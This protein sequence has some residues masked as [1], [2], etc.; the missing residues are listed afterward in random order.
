[1]SGY[2]HKRQW[3]GLQRRSLCWGGSCLL[4][5]TAGV[6][7]TIPER[8]SETKWNSSE[9]LRHWIQRPRECSR[10]HFTFLCRGGEVP[11][12]ICSLVY[13]L[14]RVEAEGIGRVD[15]MHLW[16]KWS[17]RGF[18]PGLTRFWTPCTSGRVVMSR[19]TISEVGQIKRDES[20]S[21]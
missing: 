9:S 16:S 10:R 7:E 11:K 18:F 20:K 6:V 12:P 1:M 5:R 21:G 19:R 17:V 3:W 8:L 14:I 13:S 15:S 2:H 4:I